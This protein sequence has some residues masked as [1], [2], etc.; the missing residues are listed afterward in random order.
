MKQI[1]IT[2]IPRSGTSIV[3]EIISLCGIQGGQVNSMFENIYI[4]KYLHTLLK[5]NRCDR[6]GHYPLPDIIDI[7]NIIKIH[8]E[9]IQRE[10]E[11]IGDWYY[12][13]SRITAL[14]RPFTKIFPK[15]E[16]IIVRRNED[17]IIKSCENTGYMDTFY[18]R[19]ILHRLGLENTRDGW[20]YM[21][22]EYLKRFEWLKKEV[23][24]TEIWLE[25]NKNAKY[26]IPYLMT[27]TGISIDKETY[28]KIYTLIDKKIKV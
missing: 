6:N 4:Q 5:A 14:C 9:A 11:I 17:G 26:T 10:Q 16:Y 23:K 1:L 2:G 24:V 12:K 18:N 25:D 20:R 28:K 21:I 8:I 22:E 19:E 3:A 15:A 13:D 7:P 27:R